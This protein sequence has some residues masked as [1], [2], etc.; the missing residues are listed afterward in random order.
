MG[1]S[2]AQLNSAKVQGQPR[3]ARRTGH[4]EMQVLGRQRGFSLMEIM[5]ALVVAGALL[6]IGVPSYLAHVERVRVSQAASDIAAVS[7]ALANFHALRFTYPNSLAELNINIPL[8]PWGRPY[9]YLGIDVNPPPNVGKVRRDKNLNPLNSD[10][11]LYSV[12]KD[13]ASSTQITGAKG[14][15]DIIRAGNGGFIGLAKDH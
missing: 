13:G 4:S 5:M 12:G 11:D 1:D 14:R 15:D 9:R 3:Y 8:D 10:F 7:M 2:P 6:A